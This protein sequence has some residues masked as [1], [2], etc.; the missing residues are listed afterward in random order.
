MILYVDKIVDH[1]LGNYT[2]FRKVAKAN[3]WEIVLEDEEVALG[4]DG[5]LYEKDY[6]PEK[7]NDLLANEIR[8]KRDDMLSSIKWRI[9][10]FEEQTYMGIP[11]ND[12]EEDYRNIL[13]YKQYLRDITTDENF[14]N[15]ELKTLEEFLGK[16]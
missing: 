3:G 13:K 1:R 6:L 5:N 9:E 4:Y 7:S 8:N 15:I 16:N 2:P 11:T 10:R 14:P 12:T